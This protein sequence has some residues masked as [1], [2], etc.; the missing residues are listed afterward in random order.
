MFGLL[1]GFQTYVMIGLV[2]AFLASA[3]GF[4][5]YFQYSQG[6]IDQLVKTAS[7]LEQTVQVQRESINLLHESFTKQSEQA[8]ELSK[9]VNQIQVETG[10]LA[11]TFAKHDLGQLA[12]QKPTLI[13]RTINDATN[14]VLKDLETITNPNALGTG[15]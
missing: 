2:V 10:K 11:K 13:E 7:Q 14:K 1:K 4:Y 15:E 8:N 5:Y 3:V 6:K 9:K 12:K